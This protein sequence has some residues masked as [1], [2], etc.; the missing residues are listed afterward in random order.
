MDAV[1]NGFELP[2][3]LTEWSEFD[4]VAGLPGPWVTPEKY[5]LIERFKFF[6]DLASRRSRWPLSWLERI[7]QAR[8]ERKDFRWPV[9]MLV[10]QRLRPAPKLS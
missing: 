3:T 6:L 7:A 8:C 4:Y 1:A 5:E 10:M 2:A 9:E